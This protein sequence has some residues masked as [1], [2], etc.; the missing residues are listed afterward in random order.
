M[1]LIIGN[2]LYSSWSLRPWLL[3]RA[4]HIPFQEIV[5]PMRTE[6]FAK[7]VKDYSP[8]GKV[9]VLIDGDTVVWESLAIMDYL[10]DSFADCGIWPNDLKALAMARSI[11]AEM[12]SGF[13]HLRRE[14]PMNLGKRYERQPLSEAVQGDVDRIVNI[15][16]T[17][18]EQFGSEGPFLFGNFSAAD[19]MFAP[20]VTRFLTYN[21]D[22][23]CDIAENYGNTMLNL[24][25][26]HQW[27]NSALL[28]PWTIEASELSYPILNDYRKELDPLP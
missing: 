2:K 1:K 23:D 11:A 7:E 21:I 4:F 10:N 26:F 25:P 12:H 6:Q 16:R 5:L 17:A 3:M 20:V 13:T 18:R 28:E 8:A 9:P 22:L 15:W 19:A 24:A 27:R 14:C